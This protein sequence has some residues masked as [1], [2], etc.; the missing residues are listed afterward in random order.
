MAAVNVA[1]NVPFLALPLPTIYRGIDVKIRVGASKENVAV[2]V[3]AD[4]VKVV[5]IDGAVELED[6]WSI[7]LTA[8]LVLVDL[9]DRIVCVLLP[10][11]RVDI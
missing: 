9:F 8:I 10:R 11:T 4:P 2:T 7:V 6:V 5:D 3:S 1:D